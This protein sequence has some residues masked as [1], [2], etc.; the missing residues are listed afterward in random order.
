M[1][2]IQSE[3]AFQKKSNVLKKLIPYYL[4]INEMNPILVKMAQFLVMVSS[5]IIF[6]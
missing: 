2:Q 6:F 4:K 1:Y 5:Y 3:M